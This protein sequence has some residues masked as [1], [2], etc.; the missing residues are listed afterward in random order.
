MQFINH[1]AESNW[2]T[3]TDGKSSPMVTAVNRFAERWANL[4]EQRMAQRWVDASCGILPWILRK[5]RAIWVG[6]SSVSDVAWAA[7]DDAD[8]E[9]ISGN[10][11]SFAVLA[12]VENWVH[13]RELLEWQ[14]SRFPWGHEATLRDELLDDLGRPFVRH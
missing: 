13:G 2:N 10:I 11:F 9:G 6:R 8:T 7:S 4:M 3:N 14:N 12:L 5:L 1:E